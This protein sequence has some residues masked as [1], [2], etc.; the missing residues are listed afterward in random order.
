MEIDCFG[1]KRWWSSFENILFIFLI[2][3]L[4]AIQALGKPFKGQRLCAK[5]ST[6]TLKSESHSFVGHDW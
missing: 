2:S 4:M 1:S 3:L 6:G 5:E